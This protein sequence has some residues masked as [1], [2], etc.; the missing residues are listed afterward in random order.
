MRSYQG[1][2]ELKKLRIL[3]LVS[4]G[5]S[6]LWAAEQELS[7]VDLVKRL[8][9]L[10]YLATLPAPGEQCAQWSSY[11]RAS[12]YDAATG[13]YVAWDANGDGDGI[14]R[15]EG[16]QAGLGRDGRPGLHLAHLVGRAQGRPCA[17]LPGRRE[18]AG[19]GPA[20]CRLLRPQER[21]LHPVGASCTRSPW[22]GTTTRP[23]PTRN[24]ARSSPTRAGA[25]IIIS[26]TGPFPRAR[27]CPPSSGNWPPQ[28]WRRW[29]RPTRC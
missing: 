16:E 5:C 12:R 29:T 6:T 26:P 7:Y 19:G 4:L 25:I 23:S 15:K 24:R 8:T 2:K 10:E 3:V 9:D 18:R 14:I 11:D 27:R 22:A 13:K 1:L 21:A 17:H 28:T 20:V